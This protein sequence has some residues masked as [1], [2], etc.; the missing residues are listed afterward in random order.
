MCVG[1]DMKSVCEGRASGRNARHGE[2]EGSR[3]VIS[4]GGTTGQRRLG[5]AD[6]MSVGLRVVGV[7]EGM[8]VKDGC[9]AVGGRVHGEGPIHSVGD[10]CGSEARLRLGQDNQP[11]GGCSESEVEG[12]TY[13]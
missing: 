12:R 13:G 4:V 1:G 3:C 2:G 7:W 8:H 5:M 6:G 9:V 10:K 11:D